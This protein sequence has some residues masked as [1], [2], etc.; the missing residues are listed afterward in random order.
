MLAHLQKHLSIFLISCASLCSDEIVEINNIHTSNQSNNES[1]QTIDRWIESGCYEEAQQACQNALASNN[2]EHRLL[3]QFK[4]GQVLFLLNRFE[5]IE[6]LFE[7]MGSLTESNLIPS[8]VYL[9][10]CAKHSLGKNQSAIEYLDLLFKHSPIDD[11]IWYQAKLL[12]ATILW[13]DGKDNDAYQKANLIVQSCPTEHIQTQA[14]L[15]MSQIDQTKGRIEQ[16][17]KR[18]LHIENTLPNDHSLLY[19]V[20]LLLGKIYATNNEYDLAISSYQK[21]LSHSF[22]DQPNVTLLLTLGQLFLKDGLSSHS[23]ESLKKAYSLLKEAVQLSDP[24]L[25]PE[26]LFSLAQASPSHQERQSIYQQLIDEPSSLYLESQLAKAIDLYQEGKKWA[27]KNSI[28]QAKQLYLQAAHDFEHLFTQAQNKD[29]PL[30]AKALLHQVKALVQSQGRE[31]TSQALEIISSYP[32]CLLN[33]LND[34]GEVLL[35]H[36]NILAQDPSVHKEMAIQLWKQCIR[37][38]PDLSSSSQALFALAN[39]H[40]KQDQHR[41]AKQLYL[42]FIEHFPQSPQ[43]GDA[44]FFLSR[45]LEALGEEQTTV[46]QYKQRC[47]IDYPQGSYAPEAY[48]SY[49]SYEDYLLRS[50]SCLSHLEQ[51]IDRFPQSPWTLYAYYFLGMDRKRRAFFHELSSEEPF[52]KESIAFFQRGETLYDTCPHS[53]PK[54]QHEIFAALRYHMSMERAKSYLSLAEMN[55]GTKQNV[56]LEY[57]I[58][59]FK[60]IYLSSQTKEVSSLVHFT[61]PTLYEESSLALASVLFQKEEWNEAKRL[62]SKMIEHCQSTNITRGHFLAQAWILQGKIALLHQNSLFALQS[63]QQ[64]QEA[65][66]GQAL[67]SDDHLDLLI[68]K[69]HCYLTM[70][71]HKQAMRILSDVVNA[72]VV[73]QKRLEAMYLRS[74]IYQQQERHELAKLQLES[75]SNKGGSWADLAKKE[76]KEYGTTH[77]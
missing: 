3:Y 65:S 16:A 31:Q 15:L 77:F 9:I 37:D 62:L 75:L 55:Q 1:I 43:I 73:S 53:Q 18:L 7:P 32:I 38:Y 21:C 48:F 12:L 74:K 41:L 47:F 6:P 68:Q 29:N 23:D 20:W 24:S 52:L 64:A 28:E 61:Y 76:L 5:E 56:Y 63:F 2:K 42:D 45:S 49:Y 33:E 66:A 14:N 57:A 36:A 8:S 72:Q 58:D 17:K 30:A 44:L 67:S 71:R 22:S 34:P 59:L 39:F 27:Q 69:S 19:K 35:L 26:A 40:S 10:A 51:M 60:D 50:P 13:E 11:P 70:Q 46:Q 25:Q 4:L 54:N